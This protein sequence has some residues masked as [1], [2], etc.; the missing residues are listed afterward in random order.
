[1]LKEANKVNAQ[2]S[3]TIWLLVAQQPERT[4]TLDESTTHPLYELDYARPGGEKS[5]MLQITARQMS[6]PLPEQITQLAE[7]LLGTSSHPLEDMT[8]VGLGDYPVHYCMRLLA[9]HAILQ[10]GTWRVPQ[11]EPAPP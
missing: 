10:D 2:L 3:R 4:I 5:P 1:M 11:P 8:A 7:R 9:P 6:E